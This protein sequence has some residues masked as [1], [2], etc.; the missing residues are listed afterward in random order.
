MA[1]KY[2][3][4]KG[5]DVAINVNRFGG[6]FALKGYAKGPYKDATMIGLRSK[7]TPGF[8]TGR[9]GSAGL[10]RVRRKK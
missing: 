7:R 9:M 6:F 8:V 10:Y 3:L 1:K 5:T 2:R 4:M